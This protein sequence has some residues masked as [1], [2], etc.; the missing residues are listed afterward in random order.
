MQNACSGKR[1]NTPTTACLTV[2]KRQTRPAMTLPVNWYSVK[3]GRSTSVHRFVAAHC[4][5]CMFQN[6]G[7]YAPSFRTKPGIL[8]PAHSRPFLPTASPQSKARQKVAPV[9]SS[10]TARLL[11]K[12]RCRANRCLISTGSSSFSPGGRIRSVQSTRWSQYRSV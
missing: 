2:S 3:A 1:L 7:R 6:S 5:I 11:K 4:V 8:L 12:H 9:T 10:I